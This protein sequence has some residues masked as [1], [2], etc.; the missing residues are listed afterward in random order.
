MRLPFFGRHAPDSVSQSSKGTPST[1]EAML[2]RSSIP[3]R[4]LQLPFITYHLG[5]ITV[6]DP[7]NAVGPARRSRPRLPMIEYP[8]VL[9]PTDDNINLN[10]VAIRYCDVGKRGYGV[11][12][13]RDISHEDPSPIIIEAPFLS[14][15]KLPGNP[16]CSLVETWRVNEL[17]R[18]Q[19]FIDHFPE[20]AGLSPRRP[21]LSF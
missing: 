20:L 1:I 18:R 5:S 19:V 3:S 2:C 7:S 16:Q 10:G 6:T 21:N 9:G 14:F 13:R 4:L 17:Y 8:V 11:F 12:A 15:L